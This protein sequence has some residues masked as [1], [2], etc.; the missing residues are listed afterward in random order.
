DVAEG[1]AQVLVASRP[2]DEDA[3]VR[4]DEPA[5][6]PP[7]SVG[8]QARLPVLEHDRTL[9]LLPRAMLW[10]QARQVPRVDRQ[11]GHPAVVARAA[12]DAVLGK[13]AAEQHLRLRHDRR[14]LGVEEYAQP[15]G[16]RAATDAAV[17]EVDA[18]QL[19]VVAR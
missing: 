18:E 9:V 14:V 7:G 3:A 2:V 5:Q 1:V 12:T 8:A 10:K 19:R 4:P 11:H 15:L 6:K 17:A 16:P 13:A